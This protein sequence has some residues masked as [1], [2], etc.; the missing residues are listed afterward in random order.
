M[1][2]DNIS[3]TI[4]IFISSNIFILLLPPYTCLFLLH[5]SENEQIEIKKSFNMAEV[6]NYKLSLNFYKNVLNDQ[7]DALLDTEEYFRNYLRKENV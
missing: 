2:C 7:Y 4:T 1:G 3:I 6:K 5:P